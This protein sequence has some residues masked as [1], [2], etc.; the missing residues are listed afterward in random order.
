MRAVLTNTAPSAIVL[1]TEDAKAHLRVTHSSEDAEIAA[2]V[3]EA[4]EDIERRTGLVLRPATYTFQSS[5]FRPVFHLPH[6]PVTAIS[7]VKYYPADS[8]AQTTLATSQYTSQLNTIPATVQEA[9]GA[10]WPSVFRRPNAVEIEYTAGYASGDVPNPLL[11]AIKIWIDCE[12]HC[13]KGDQLD[14]KQRALTN[15]LRQWEVR[16]PCLVGLHN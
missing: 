10:S 11:R 2:M 15:I 6:A 9:Y 12:W 7:S 14:R 16:H 1:S 8:G 5:V 13:Y 3:E 4:T